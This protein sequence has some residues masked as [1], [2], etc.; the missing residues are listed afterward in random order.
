VYKKR[1]KKGFNYQSKE[2]KTMVNKK[3]WLGILVMVLVFGMTVIGCEE[4]QDNGNDD[5]GGYSKNIIITGL[6]GYDG[7]Y[8][9][10]TGM[11]P[12]EDIDGEM[13]INGNSVTLALGS[14]TELDYKGNGSFVLILTLEDNNNVAGDYL[15]AEKI[16]WY[17]NGGALPSS[18][19]IEDC[20]MFTIKDRN[21]TIGFDKFKEINP[22]LGL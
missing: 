2:E 4:E 6:S 9:R 3:I 8:A 11:N 19:Y 20:P 21:S 15:Y 5:G 14:E 16:F 22:T 7:W 17:T 13:R 12:Q 18:G 1:Y 10:I